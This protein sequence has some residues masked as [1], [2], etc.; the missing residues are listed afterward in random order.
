MADNTQDA[1]VFGNTHRSELWLAPYQKD[2]DNL[3]NEAS[4]LTRVVG[5]AVEFPGVSKEY[6][7]LRHDLGTQ[8]GS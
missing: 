6:R 1:I 2:L 5:N 7:E 3:E 4:A 8:S